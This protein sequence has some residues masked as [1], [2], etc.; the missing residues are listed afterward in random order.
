M[1]SHFALQAGLI[2]L[3]LYIYLG[4]CLT[5]LSGLH[6]ALLDRLSVRHSDLY[7][8]LNENNEFTAFIDLFNDVLGSRIEILCLIINPV[9]L[10]QGNT[11]RKCQ[12]YARQ[13]TCQHLGIQCYSSGT[14]RLPVSTP[15]SANHLV[16]HSAS[17]VLL[18]LHERP[19]PLES[20]SLTSKS[21]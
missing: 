13:I 15:E 18:F 17:S 7:S 19:P 6:I 3:R 5:M 2:F 16:A 1:I 21:D 10:F 4:G 14:A 9:L 8:M 20:P 12:D 11:L